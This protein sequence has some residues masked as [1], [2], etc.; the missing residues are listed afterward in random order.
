MLFRRKIPEWPNLFVWR[1]TYGEEDAG[2][3]PDYE[4]DKCI[5]CGFSL[6]Y[7]S[8]EIIYKD[9]DAVRLITQH[10]CHNCGWSRG[11]DSSMGGIG[12]RVWVNWWVKGLVAFPINDTNV[13]ISELGTHLKNNFRDVYHLSSRRFE[14]LIGEIFKELGYRIVLTPKT[15]DGGVDLFV[16]QKT[17]SIFAVVECKKYSENRKVGVYAVDRLLG[18]ALVHGSDNAY[19]VTTSSFTA[20]AREHANSRHIWKKR[21]NINL[22][23]AGELFNMLNVYNR[24]LQPLDKEWKH[25]CDEIDQRKRFFWLR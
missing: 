4:E 17:N 1:E 18:S 15:R 23:D 7:E 25:R 22:V 10:S 5:Y 6:K 2:L 3:F 8:K 11:D 14:E 19:L 13:A 24:D 20:P 16:F 9:Q 21:I 12:S